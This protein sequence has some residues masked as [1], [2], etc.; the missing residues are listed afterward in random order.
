[1]P[2]FPWSKVRH[3]HEDGLRDIGSTSS[4][5]GLVLRR[6]TLCAFFHTLFHA[7]AR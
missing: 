5:G 1:M 6:S 2:L 4:Q 7:G 3:T